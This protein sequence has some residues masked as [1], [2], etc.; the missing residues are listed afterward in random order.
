MVMFGPEQFQQADKLPEIM[1]KTHL[2]APPEVYLDMYHTNKTFEEA[3]KETQ[4][5]FEQFYQERIE[6]LYI[7]INHDEVIS[8]LLRNFIR[9]IISFLFL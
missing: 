1:G 6:P 8:N 4:A 2:A 9:L 7:D 3:V 5:D